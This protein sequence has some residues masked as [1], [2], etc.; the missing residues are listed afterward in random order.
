MFWLLTKAVWRNLLYTTLLHEH[1]VMMS[2]HDSRHLQNLTCLQLSQTELAYPRQI[3]FMSSKFPNLPCTPTSLICSGHLPV[4][5]PILIYIFEV[6]P[7]PIYLPFQ[8]SFT[9]CM[10]PCLPYTSPSKSDLH[11]ASL[12][13]SV[14]P[15]LIYIWQVCL[16]CTPL[17]VWFT[18]CRP[19]CLPCTFLP[20]SHLHLVIL[21]VWLP[22]T[23]P[24][25]SHLHLANILSPI[26]FPFQ[27]WLC[28]VSLP[29]S[30]V[31]PSVSFTSC[32]SACL[33]CTSHK[34]HIQLASLPVSH[35]PTSLSYIFQMS[36]IYLASQVWFT[37]YKSPS[38]QFI[39]HKS[40][41]H[42]AILPVSH[43][44]PL[45]S[46]IY[47]LQISISYVLLTSDLHPASLSSPI[48]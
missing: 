25:K 38:L 2:P 46:L 45:T 18:P 34:S 28:C 12:P 22:C 44:L 40:S 35:V 19:V 29:V 5:P 9:F 21:Q 1:E 27:I 47:A 23:S 31:P 26:Y 17:P 14:V 7:S 15:S 36:R 41:I 24:P 39:Y 8:V 4:P 16:P 10:S 13:V 33:P 43:V 32:K 20:R 3:W 11:H 30:H 37:F 48:Y 42:L 6:S